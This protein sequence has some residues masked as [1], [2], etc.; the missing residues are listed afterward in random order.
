MA[1]DKKATLYANFY[2]GLVYLQREMYEDAENFFKKTLDIGPNMIEA[3]YELGRAQWFG[4]NRDAAK[5]TW[6]AGFA[7]NK[8]NPW[9]KKCRDMLATVDA[10]GRPRRRSEARLTRPEAAAILNRCAEFRAPSLDSSSGSSTPPCSSGRPG[11]GR[12]VPVARTGRRRQRPSCS[13]WV[14]AFFC[15]S[16]SSCS[17]YESTGE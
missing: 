6:Q 17:R 5:A 12:G 15:P 10:G 8:F 4:G 3:Y 7:A 9:G 11:L 13:W 14:T 1:N 2:L 16:A